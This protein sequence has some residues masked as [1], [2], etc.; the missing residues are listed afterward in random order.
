MIFVVSISWCKT[1]GFLHFWVISWG[2]TVGLSFYKA[3]LNVCD[4]LY[5]WRQRVDLTSWL[6]QFTRKQ[7]PA[8]IPRQLFSKLLITRNEVKSVWTPTGFHSWIRG[9][10]EKNPWVSHSIIHIPVYNPRAQATHLFLQGPFG[11]NV[12]LYLRASRTYRYVMPTS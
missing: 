11:S 12:C 9:S 10:R 7:K 1:L 3:H 6:N 4:G 2:T 5:V 8:I